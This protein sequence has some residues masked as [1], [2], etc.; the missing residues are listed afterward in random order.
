MTSTESL[1][2]ERILE[3]LRPLLATHSPTGREDEAREWVFAWLSDRLAGRGEVKVDRAGNVVARLPGSGSAPAVA[4]VA[5]L[6]EI[7]FIV[8]R[9]EPDGRIRVAKVGGSHPWKYGEGPVDL[10]GRNG[11]VPAFLSFGAMHASEESKEIFAARNSTNL[12]W[13]VCWVDAKLSPDELAARGIHAGVK[14]VLSR[15]RKITTEIGAYLGAYA[16]DDKALAAVML[17]LCEYLLAAPAPGD[18]YLIASVGEE[19]GSG[20]A[21]FAAGEIPAETFVA[22]EVAPVLPEYALE[23]TAQPV[24]LYKDE[25]NIYDESLCFE[26]EDA[27]LSCGLA[28]QRAVLS[29]FG[30]DLS[31]GARGGRIGRY[32]CIAIPCE[33]THGYEIIHRDT[34]PA[35]ARTL[36]AWVR[37]VKDRPG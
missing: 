25:Y 12:K 13:E 21:V 37:G 34:L 2:L 27:A 10:L 17:S 29:S 15:S 7:G 30:S 36:D 24:I 22:L 23:A 1:G 16:L 11:I 8:K 33:N 26:L 9:I 32:G 6:D 18:V 31:F 20:R 28:P 3:I 19:I 35:L 14:G 5:H 4:L